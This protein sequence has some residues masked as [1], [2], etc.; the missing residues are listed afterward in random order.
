MTHFPDWQKLVTTVD[1]NV[2][3]KCTLFWRERKLA[4]TTLENNFTLSGKTEGTQM[5]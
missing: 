2:S 4:Q 1:K 5:Y 3:K